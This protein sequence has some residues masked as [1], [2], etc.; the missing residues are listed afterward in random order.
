MTTAIYSAV[1]IITAVNKNIH[2]IPPSNIERPRSVSIGGSTIIGEQPSF[3]SPI[4]NDAE[5]MSRHNNNIIRRRKSSITSFEV[6]PRALTLSSID[7]DTV[8]HIGDADADSHGG[9]SADLEAVRSPSA[10]RHHKGD[11]RNHELPDRNI[12]S[13]T[14]RKSDIARHA[15]PPRDARRAITVDGSILL[16]HQHYNHG[17]HSADGVKRRRLSK[18]ARTRLT[19]REVNSHIQPGR[20]YNSLEEGPSCRFEQKVKTITLPKTIDFFRRVEIKL[21]AVNVSISV[22]MTV[23]VLFACPEP[24]QRGLRDSNLAVSVSLF[25]SLICSLI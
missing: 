23:F 19:M 9:T 25:I 1:P 21:I 16:S 7:S 14:K 8:E 4:M 17:L 15:T 20:H 22:V 13:G 24:W 11:A 6:L 10:P 3:A 5:I 12:P 2:Q 18:R